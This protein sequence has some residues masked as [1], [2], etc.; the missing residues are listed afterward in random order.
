M[1]SQCDDRAGAGLGWAGF[2]R[3]QQL[4]SNSDT[5]PGQGGRQIQT[6]LVFLGDIVSRRESQ[7]FIFFSM[8]LKVMLSAGT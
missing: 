3:W 8:F 6:G 2:T 7:D 4:L 1:G 5:Q